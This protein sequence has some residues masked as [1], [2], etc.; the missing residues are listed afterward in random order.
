MKQHKHDLVQIAKEFALKKGAYEKLGINLSHAL[1]LL[2]QEKEINYLSISHRVKDEQSFLEKIERKSYENP[3]E[4]TEDFCGIRVICYY[5][6]DVDKIAE[7]INDEFDIIS[8]E[9]KEELLNPDQF[10]YRSNHFIVRIKSNWTQAPNYRGIENYKAEI[11]VRT[12]LMHAW[13]EIE[14]KLAY[15]K[16][17]HMPNQFKRKLYLISAK[18]EEADNQFEEMRN[19]I[20][21]YKKDIVEIAK[22]PSSIDNNVEL[23][24]DSLQAFLDEK[25][26]EKT[27]SIQS[28]IHLLDE[29]NL[30]KISFAEL[31][32][33]YEKTKD[34]LP[35]LEDETFKGFS[36]KGTG[37]AQVGAARAIMDLTNENYF[38]LREK[39]KHIIETRSKW[40]KKVSDK[41]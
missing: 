15:K 23:N 2:I 26:P 28:T 20:L 8:D 19:A 5:Q 4:E 32:S 36:S 41:T 21:S 40:R 10:G 38:T 39:P 25:F 33:S 3:F 7:I 31:I 35:K 12:V 37:W 30:H 22:T 14:H 34:I 27:K 11:Q 6:S 13:A 1:E 17:Q 16:E 29:F 24:L 9:N 18:L